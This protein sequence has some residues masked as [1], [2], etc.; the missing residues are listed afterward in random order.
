MYKLP[1]GQYGYVVNLPQNIATFINSLPRHPTDL[2]IVIV[3][4]Q[5][6]N[7]S[8]HDFRVRRSKVLNALNWLMSNNIYFRNI[9]INNG[10]LA[11]LPE[12]DNIT[13]IRTVTISSE[14]SFNS[15]PTQAEE[16]YTAD[17]SRTFIPHVYEHR[18]EQQH[19]QQSLEQSMSGKTYTAMWPTRSDTP[20]NEFNTPGYFTS[21]F[22]TLFPTGAVD[23]SAPHIHTVN[24]CYYTEM[25]DLPNTTDFGTLLLIQR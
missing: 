11:C 14:E 7:Q 18:T 5:Q 1:H 9:T 19:I 23:F 21:A 13:G 16:P 4:Q 12:D 3:R 22:P 6:S 20:I 17:L 10:N 15:E 8:H 24:T 2:D 25:A